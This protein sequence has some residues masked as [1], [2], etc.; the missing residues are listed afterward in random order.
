MARIP[1]TS[2]FELIPEG[3]YVFRIYDVIYDEDFGKMQIKMV[4]AK[5]QTYI[6]RFSL[7]SDKNTFNDKAMNA[8]A[9]FAKN[10]L[11]DF[12]MADVDPEDL[13]DHYI[14][15]E[16]IHTKSE[17]KKE[18]GRMLTFANL[19][20]KAPAD[21]FDEEPVPKALSLGRSKP[22]AASAPAPKPETPAFSVK[23]KNLASLLGR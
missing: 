23:P 22:A 6:E 10:A 13:I 20:D 17:S 12:S 19:G 18:P 16:V 8:F 5:G 2:G 21:G 9:Y 14:E 7:K 15:A 4:T 1:I 3:T 11:N